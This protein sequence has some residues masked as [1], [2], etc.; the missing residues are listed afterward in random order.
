MCLLLDVGK[1]QVLDVACPP[2]AAR[3]PS[4]AGARRAHRRQLWAR[5]GSA[6]LRSLARPAR[7]Q[8]PAATCAGGA[9][10]GERPAPAP[11]PPEPPP[12]A[13]PAPRS[14]L[15]PLAG[16]AQREHGARPPLPG[17]C[18]RRLGARAVAGRLMPLVSARSASRCPAPDGGRL[19]DAHPGSASCPQGVTGC[20]PRSGGDGHAAGSPS[21]R[22]PG[23]GAAGWKRR[24]AA[25]SSRVPS[26]KEPRTAYAVELEWERRG[27]ESHS[28]T[29]S[30]GKG[31]CYNR[32]QEWEEQRRAL[33]WPKRKTG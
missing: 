5:R 6:P 1:F 10:L 4:T 25:G 31:S 18:G 33:R 20:R 22:L 7:S 24:K 11:G 27:E 8:Q 23:Q 32:S 28:G 16:A 21:A 19:E 15:P 29:Y 26:E 13:A 17:G 30:N 14:P 3:L 2:A 12:G 9:V